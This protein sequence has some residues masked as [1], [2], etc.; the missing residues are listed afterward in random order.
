MHENNSQ[1]L[2]KTWKAVNLSGVIGFPI[3]LIHL[4][5]KDPT[6]TSVVIKMRKLF[7]F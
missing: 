5:K 4:G 7:L 1:D 3:I 2:H 6:C